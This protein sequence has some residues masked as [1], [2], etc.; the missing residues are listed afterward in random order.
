MAAKVSPNLT[1]YLDLEQFVKIDI[2]SES[3]QISVT[4]KQDIKEGTA[5]IREYPVIIWKTDDWVDFFKKFKRLT[6]DDQ[7]A[8]TNMNHPPLSS[9][10]LLRELPVIRA[11]CATNTDIFLARKLSS[12]CLMHEREYNGEESHTIGS[13]AKSA[14]FLFSSRVSRSCHPNSICTSHTSD[15]KLAIKVIKD[16]PEGQALSL[17]WFHLIWTKSTHLRRK[18]CNGIDHLRILKCEICRG[19]LICS[20][21]ASQVP[22]WICNSCGRS[23][24]RTICE[25]KEELLENLT[26]FNSFKCVMMEHPFW[27]RNLERNISTI[28]KA[29]HPHHYLVFNVLKFYSFLCENKAEEIEETHPFL[30]LMFPPHTNKFIDDPERLRSKAAAGTMKMV[31]KIECIASGCNGCNHTNGENVHPIVYQSV[32]MIFFIG[33]NLTKCHRLMWPAGARSMIQRYL[34]AMKLVH[35]EFSSDIEA[36]ERIILGTSNVAGFVDTFEL[37]SVTSTDDHASQNI[38]SASKSAA[39]ANVSP[40]GRSQLKPKGKGKKKRG[41]G[42]TKKKKKRGH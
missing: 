38:A 15:G 23:A 29:L 27:D 13:S 37:L 26:N 1:K 30:R 16:V 34:P 18:G 14:L 28:E 7:A 41:G 17:P 11:A 2:S 33:V 19:E 3:E 25:E 4:T 8:I 9:P 32:N 36:I 20:Y 24:D 22:S 12:V 10:E 39:T 35:G 21:D 42:S 31:S 6:E 40:P 5:V